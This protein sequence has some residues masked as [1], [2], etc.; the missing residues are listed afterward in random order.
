L[1][2]ATSVAVFVA[3]ATP[4]LAQDTVLDALNDLNGGAAPG[5]EEIQPV[6]DALYGQGCPRFPDAPIEAPQS[7][8]IR[9]RYSSDDPAQPE[10]LMQLYQFHCYSGAYNVVY[11]FFGWDPDTGL[12]PIGLS[13]PQFDI[14]YEGET[15]DSPVKSIAITGYTARFTAVNAEY[16]PKTQTIVA[17]S[18]WRGIGDASSGGIWTFD[19]GEFRLVEYHVDAT[20]DGEMNP[21]TIVDFQKP[22]PVK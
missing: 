14:E 5:V 22:Q 11:V 4:V 8:E 10:R 1:R 17:G 2:F 7:F 19:E 13:Y 15:D 21:K 20:Y 12:R 16:D 18:A 3:L 9:F 6:F